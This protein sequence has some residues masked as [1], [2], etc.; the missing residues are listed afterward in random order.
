MIFFYQ[1]K[2]NVCDIFL[3]SS[4]NRG[5]GYLL[6]ASSEYLQAMFS[7]EIR[8]EYKSSKNPAFLYKDGIEGSVVKIR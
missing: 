8:K 6:E 2:Y 4:Q 1:T 3:I 7:A 5:C